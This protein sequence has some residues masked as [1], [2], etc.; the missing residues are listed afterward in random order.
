MAASRPPRVIS[1]AGRSIW[2]SRPLA[3]GTGDSPSMRNTS[4]PSR[5]VQAMPYAVA[6]G[7]S[8]ARALA[9][10][11][12]AYPLTIPV[13]P[14]TSHA[15]PARSQTSAATSERSASPVR[16]FSQWP[17][18]QLPASPHTSSRRGKAGNGR[19]SH[20]HNDTP[21]SG[22]MRPP[23]AAYSAD[24]GLFAESDQNAWNASIARRWITSSRAPLEKC[25]SALSAL[26]GS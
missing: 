20:A 3:S 10:P 19:A 26:L 11:S 18:R 5:S 15:T 21:S 14:L 9:G 8:N 12:L 2:I 17:S 1:I 24:T 6:N 4:T 16:P 22:T 23:C 25:G 7:S 13:S